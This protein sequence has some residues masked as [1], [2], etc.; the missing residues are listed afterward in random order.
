M[1]N[2]L[3]KKLGL[4]L[5]VLT[6]GMTVIP[7]GESAPVVEAASHVSAKTV[8]TTTASLN[9]RTGASTKYKTILTIPKGKTVGMVSY[10]SSWSKVLYSGKSGYVSTKY[11]KKNHSLYSE[12]R[13][14]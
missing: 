12:R 11:L 2:K 3:I 6:V 8:Y 14:V 10:N 7:F 9:M 4:S 5:V 13:K 1:K